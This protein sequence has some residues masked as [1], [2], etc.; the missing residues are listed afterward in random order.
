MVKDLLEHIQHPLARDGT[1]LGAIAA[2]PTPMRQAGTAPHRRCIALMARER[3]RHPHGFVA[4]RLAWRQQRRQVLPG[5]GAAAVV[6][7]QSALPHLHHQ[8]G[9][10]HPGAL[11]GPRDAQRLGLR[12]NL[13]VLLEQCQNPN[14]GVVLIDQLPL[15]CQGLQ[16]RKD[17][18]TTVADL[19]NL[20]PLGGIGYRDPLHGLI[21][22]QAVKRQPQIVPAHHQHGPRPRAEFLLP[23]FTRQGR[24]EHLTTR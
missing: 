12:A 18:I 21:V 20:V 5:V 17:H 15:G 3:V 22:L 24:G 13:V 9:G 6:Q 10:A 16:V 7:T 8:G 1:D 19:L 4:L 23:R 14:R 11:L 2:L